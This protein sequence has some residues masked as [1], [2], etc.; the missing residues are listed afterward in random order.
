MAW[1]DGASSA[2]TASSGSSATQAA[3]ILIMGIRLRWN[4]QSL[5][6]SGHRG[7]PGA[8]RYVPCCR[9]TATPGHQVELAL[10]RTRFVVSVC[11]VRDAALPRLVALRLDE[12]RRDIGLRA[13]DGVLDAIDA[14]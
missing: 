3:K 14:T 4:A 6:C 1:P 13:L 5:D 11:D 2:A 8:P 7:E 10:G 9:S 12:E